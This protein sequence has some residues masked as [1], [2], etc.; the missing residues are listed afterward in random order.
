MSNVK[1]QIPGKINVNYNNMIHQK[2]S[3]GNNDVSKSDIG[4][5]DSD[6]SDRQRSNSNKKKRPGETSSDTTTSDE[7]EVEESTFSCLGGDELSLIHI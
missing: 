4:D 7:D 2:N 3:G 1:Y 5:S 6:D